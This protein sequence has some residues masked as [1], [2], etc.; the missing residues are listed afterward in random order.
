M[1]QTRRDFIKSTGAALVTTAM[2][3]ELHAQSSASGTCKFGPLLH[4]P[5]GILNLPQD[6]SYT[7]LDRL[8]D[9]MSDG[10]LVPGKPD[11]MACFSGASGEYILMRN[12]E[13]SLND[14]DN[15]PFKGDT[16]IPVETYDPRGMG[17][18]TRVRIDSQTLETLS[19]NLVLAG[20][21]R[22]CAGGPSPWG[23]LSCE[24]T[25]LPGHGY[26]FLTNPLAEKLEAPR[27]V[28][29]YGRL[30]HEAVAIDPHTHAAYLTEDRKTGCLY[31]MM[32]DDKEHPFEGSL[33]ALRVVD[34]ANAN[35]AL[36]NPRGTRWAVDWIDLEETDPKG[37][38][39]R[40]EAKSKGA[41]II[42]RGEGIHYHDGSVY[43]CSTTGGAAE[44]GQIFR[45]DLAEQMLELILESPSTTELNMPDTICLSP[46]GDLLMAEDGSGRAYLRMLDVHGVVHNFARST[47]SKSELAGVC[48][49]PD[50]T[51]L[52]VNLQHEHLTLA[53]RG[54]F[55][56]LARHD[57]KNILCGPHAGE[58]C[59]S[60]GNTPV[61]LLVPLTA[62]AARWATQRGKNN[63]GKSNAL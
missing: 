19:S 4:D 5:R 49:S 59:T 38:T 63:P 44:K 21:V 31:R 60:A 25:V 7:V 52:F 28:T 9:V 12:H 17:G 34:L 13:V 20:T 45:L 29:A 23:W 35:L 43:I 36:S 14:T 8:G 15:G 62:L 57:S 61:S 33:Q 22:N 51:T 56:W 47:I 58:G 39:L 40:T 55:P 10:H 11:G 54:P 37:D 32:P 24:E 30:N 6:Y 1:K 18:V 46:Q 50:A 26:V 27:R 42:R 41:A 48:L 2:S 3:P 16:P 53:V